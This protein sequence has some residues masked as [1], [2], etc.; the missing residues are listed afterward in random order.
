MYLVVFDKSGDGLSGWHYKKL[1][2]LEHNWIQQS[3]IML[4]N[5]GTAKRFAEK[6]SEFGVQKIR[7]FRGTEVT[8]LFEDYEGS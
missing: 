1:H 5:R 6:L 7:I 3:T 2:E 8:E 4:E